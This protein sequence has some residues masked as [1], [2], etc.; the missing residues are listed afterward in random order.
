MNKERRRPQGRLVQRRG[1]GW[2]VETPTGRA[3]PL[4]TR[5]EAESYLV[6]LNYVAASR[7]GAACVDGDN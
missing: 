6:V 1:Q 3:G 4:P 7:L 2:Y 5:E